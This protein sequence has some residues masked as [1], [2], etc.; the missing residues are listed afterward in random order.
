MK[1]TYNLAYIYVTPQH[2]AEYIVYLTLYKKQSIHSVR[3]IL[4]AIAFYSKLKLGQDPTKSFVISKLLRKYTTEHKT[5]SIRKP[6]TY[7]LLN[8]LTKHL[9]SL[10]I[11]T[12]LRTAFS[13]LYHFM[14]HAALRISEVCLTATPE[15]ILQ[16]RY[17]S[18]HPGRSMIKLKLLSYKYCNNVPVTIGIPCT[19]SLKRCYHKYLKAR[20]SKPGP[21]FCH[22]NLSPF[23]RHEISNLLKRQLR[24]LN[25]N[26]NHYNTHSFRSGKATDMAMHGASDAQ[27][28]T[29]G[30][31]SSNAYKKYIKPHIIY[32]HIGAH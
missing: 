6:I 30:R 7:R 8:I 20:I 1:I 29:F 12:Y 15:H 18:F 16:Y 19:N 10:P 27:I 32:P 28:S 25:Y 24:L 11:S 14:Y 23:K 3:S 5:T 13:L 4:S 22:K 21:F 17:V 26:P 31:W 2:I 9:H